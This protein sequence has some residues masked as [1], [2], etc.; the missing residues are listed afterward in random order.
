MRGRVFA[1]P[2]VFRY[3]FTLVRLFLVFHLNLA[4]SSIEEEQRP[5]VVEKCYWPLLRLVA[6][7]SLPVGIEAPAWTLRTIQAIDPAWLEELRRLL[8][9][10][11]CEFIGSGFAQV[12]GPLVPAEINDANLRMGDEV[13][14]ELLGLR[15]KV[16]LVNEQ[17]YS[18]GLV[19]IYRAAG[20]TAIIMEWDNARKHH[21]EWNDELRYWP[22][23]AVGNDGQAIALIW[24]KSV[25][26]Q[27]MQRYAHGETEIA[28][29]LQ[30]LRNIPRNAGAFSLYGNDAEVF[31]FRPGRFETEAPLRGGEW[32]RIGTL[33]ECLQRDPGFTF[34]RPS[35][36][37]ELLHEPGA[38]N[39]LVLENPSQ[40]VPV[41][42]QEK[43]NLTRWAVTGRDNLAINTA[44]W[45]I[46]E[47]LKGKREATDEEW[48][49]LCY[50]WSSDFRTHI[51]ARRWE[52][53]QVRLNQFSQ[54]VSRSES[55]PR[56]V[57]EPDKLR[58]IRHTLDGE[59]VVVENDHVRAVLNCRKGLAL[60]SLEFK[61]ASGLPLCGT[62]PHGYFDDISWAADYY[63]G[64]LIFEGPGMRKVT[65]LEPCKPAIDWV[66]GRLQVSADIQTKLGSV[67]KLWRFSESSPSVNLRYELNWPDPILGSLRLGHV[68]LV[69]E[70]FDRR[71]LF[72]ATH[73]GGREIEKFSLN[74]QS[75][76]HGRNVSFVVSAAHAVGITQGVVEVGDD[77]NI[78]RIQVDKKAAALVGMVRYQSVGDKFFYRISFSARE[79]DDTGKVAPLGKLTC[80]FTLA[81]AAMVNT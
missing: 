34:I 69:P 26:F 68:T 53:Y 32:E 71:S 77:R 65:D 73:N 13:Y 18:A 47:T 21:P 66:D 64:H 4:F 38:G 56:V 79:L 2:R 12:I 50:L 67:R 14:Q 36:V 63:T 41:K 58:R 15:P 30:Y 11:L 70:A 29:Y 9:A 55:A 42:K 46:Y 51:T 5:E 33:V 37:L 54:D 43:Y 60:V 74:G 72:Y 6:R 61:S 22:Q 8:S 81:S 27:K 7:Y 48:Q 24:N 76:D 78:L 20:Y 10:G 80:D 40:P 49:E 28:E 23:Y 45:R 62:L 17:A 44:C 52:R 35:K 25:P 16:A 31:D 1:P 3:S 75:V 19:P 39:R 59:R 57:R